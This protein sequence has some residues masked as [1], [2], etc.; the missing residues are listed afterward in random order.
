VAQISA[1]E[2]T[3]DLKKL[4]N[5]NLQLV[6]IANKM[7]LNPYAK[8]E[9][10]V[11]PYLR[12]DQFI[13]V[14]AKNDMNVEYLKD[15]LYDLLAGSQLNSESVIVTNARHIDALQ[16]TDTALEK[17]MA[18]FQQQI[19]SDF[20]AMDMRQAIYHLGE[21]TGEISTDDLLE[22]IFRNFCIGK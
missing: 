11:S 8:S 7:D 12:H 21:I 1:H 9:E 6:V 18:G 20:I 3:Q 19:T 13:P 16:K 5:K 22:H 10:Y 15:Y 14:S 2:V 17:V 4:E